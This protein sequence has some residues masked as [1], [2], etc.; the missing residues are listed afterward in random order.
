MRVACHCFGASPATVSWYDVAR[1]GLL[2]AAAGAGLAAGVPGQRLPATDAALVAL[3]ALAA[4]LVITNLANVVSTT[5]RVA[6]ND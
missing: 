3:S 1:N 6:G 2:I 4:P 5:V